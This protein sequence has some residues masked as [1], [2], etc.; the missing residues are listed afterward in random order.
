MGT[1][2]EITYDS[3][4]RG[5]GELRGLSDGAKIVDQRTKREY[6]FT[7]DQVYCA[8]PEDFDVRKTYGP[9]SYRMDA[10]GEVL[11]NCAP[12]GTD[13]EN[14]FIAQFAGLSRDED[15]NIVVNHKPGRD[16]T[17]A[18]GKP[19]YI[20]E[21]DKFFATFD[22]V[23]GKFKGMQLPASLEYMIVPDSEDNIMLAGHGWPE[24]A[25]AKNLE[26]FMTFNGYD[27]TGDSIKYSD[28]QKLVLEELDA[29][30]LDRA[31]PIDVTINKGWI[32]EF[33]AVADGLK[34]E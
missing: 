25:W 26:R 7:M 5:F 28:D 9:V 19:G 30:L 17:F 34:F 21:H 2:V 3:G 11:F 12:Y 24:S 33:Q 13:T 15:H 1:A 4:K 14:R 32:D 31:R 27:F 23:A 20:P 18:S 8:L 29:I 6:V 10:D 22:I 16:V